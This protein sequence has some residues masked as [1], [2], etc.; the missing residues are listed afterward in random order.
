MAEN[1]HSAAILPP[2]LQLLASHGRAKV[3]QHALRA[4]WTSQ[5]SRALDRSA[6]PRSRRPE[7]S[8]G[9]NRQV[10]LNMPSLT[11]LASALCG[12]DGAEETVCLVVKA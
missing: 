11:C 3:I 2:G 5:P 12:F 9:A 6:A 10:R 1:A 4:T 8:G 7:S